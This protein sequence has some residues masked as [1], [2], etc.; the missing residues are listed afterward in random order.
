MCRVAEG[1]I[2]RSRIIVAPRVDDN[3]KK[4]RKKEKTAQHN[5]PT[6]APPTGDA[7]AP[8][9]CTPVMAPTAV[10]Y[11]VYERTGYALVVSRTLT[12]SL[13]LSQALGL[14][15]LATL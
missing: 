9:S 15:R 10:R 6:L 4:E 12:L 5:H 1:Y 14:V 11:K 7:R 13:Y 3:R 8:P 2:K